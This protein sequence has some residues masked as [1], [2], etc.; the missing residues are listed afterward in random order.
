MGQGL[1][2][3]LGFGILAD[4]ALMVCIDADFESFDRVAMDLSL[5]YAYECTPWYLCI[6]LAVD[7]P[8]LQERLGL[9]ALPDEVYRCAPRR[10]RILSGADVPRVFQARRPH[11]RTVWREVQK[12]LLP[13]G[14][15]LPAAAYLVINDWS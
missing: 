8:V 14:I 9:P 2:N 11:L 6:R 4:D 5:A 13:L 7:D 12:Q 3:L 1:Y 10:A 15:R